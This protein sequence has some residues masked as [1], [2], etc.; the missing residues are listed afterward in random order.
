MAASELPLD[1][2][3]G[4]DAVPESG[5]ATDLQPDV[6]RIHRAIRREPRD[7]TE[8]NEVPPSAFWG[9]I[10]IAFVWAGWYV[11]RFGGSFDTTTHVEFASRQPAI[12]QVAADQQ[13]LA[14]SNPVE[15]GK[16]VYL[17]HCQACHQA[18]G[19]GVAGAF[20]PIVGSEWVTGDAT[21]VIRILLHGLQGPITVKGNP[22]NG[23]M[24]AWEAVLSDQEIAAVATYIRQWAPNAAGPVAADAVK[25]ER[26]KDASRTQPWTAAELRAQ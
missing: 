11:G 17:K 26:E 21:T 7:P 2:A 10:A 12:A 16:A 18:N 8:G 14:V 24:P 22:Y 19:Q 6:E 13:N 15:A 5:D 3:R 25:A 20:P 4:S 1:G 9:A 23:A